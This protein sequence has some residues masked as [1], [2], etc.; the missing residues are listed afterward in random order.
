M[1]TTNMPQWVR[2]PG[3]VIVNTEQVQRVVYIPAHGPSPY[4]PEG[5]ESQVQLVMGRDTQAFYG[6]DAEVVLAW[7]LEHL[8][9][10]VD[11]AEAEAEA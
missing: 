5:R 9:A 1:S 6:D 10:V 3:D 7:W 8:D 2:L 4:F 11:G